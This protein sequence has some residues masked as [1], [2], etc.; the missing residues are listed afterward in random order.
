MAFLSYLF[1]YNGVLVDDECVHLD[2]FRD[3]L[4][5][6]G[7]TISDSDY[8]AKYLGFDDV[9]AF[10][11]ILADNAIAFDESL[12]RS[13]IEAKSPA[14]LRRAN[15]GLSQ[16]PGAS[17]LL[18]RIAFSGAVIGIVSGALRQEIDLGLS[19]LGAQNSVRFVVSA[20]DTRSGKP[21]PEGYRYWSQA[22]D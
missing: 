3:V 19:I 5:P 11:A 22:V 20:E 18:N 2:A 7:V 8:K 4:L 17:D 1:D 6:Y 10:R 15:H 9:G 12:I 13:L 14:Y 21:D 16:F